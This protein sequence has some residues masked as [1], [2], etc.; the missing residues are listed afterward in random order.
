[1][2]DGHHHSSLIV[3]DAA[4]LGLEPIVLV[5]RSG[6]NVLHSRNLKTVVQ[7]IY[8]VEDGVFVIKIHDLPVRKDFLHAGDEVI[9]LDG[10]VKI[11]HHQE[12]AA[13]QKL[14]YLAG[15]TVGKVP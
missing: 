3:V 12:A 1:M 13:Q 10:A 4:P 2:T 8:D 6:K 7:I 5:Q 9:P 11:V 15:L 14:A